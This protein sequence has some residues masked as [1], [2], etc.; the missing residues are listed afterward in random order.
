MADE[1]VAAVA[2]RAALV[3]VD[4]EGFRVAPKRQ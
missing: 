2:N 1:I 3:W 4:D